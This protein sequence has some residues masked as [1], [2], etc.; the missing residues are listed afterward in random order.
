[1][2]KL[3]SVVRRNG[4]AEIVDA[5]MTQHID[6]NNENFSA[7]LL[8]LW[9]PFMYYIETMITDELSSYFSQ[10]EIQQIGMFAQEHNTTGKPKNKPPARHLECDFS[11]PKLLGRAKSILM[12]CISEYRCDVTI[13]SGE[14]HY[15]IYDNNVYDAIIS[16]SSDAQKPKF[17]CGPVL[18][19]DNT[20][21]G[22]RAEG[23][24]VS[25]LW[26]AGKLDLWCSDVRQDVH[27]RLG[28]TESLY[29]EEPH[30]S[31]ARVR[32]GWLFQNNNEVGLRFKKIAEYMINSQSV[33]KAKNLDNDF[34][35]LTSN[36][37]R[38]LKRICEEELSSGRR[39]TY[40]EYTKQDLGQL[41]KQYQ[42][43]EEEYHI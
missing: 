11:N 5:L 6:E 42:I 41:I 17:I 40:N 18:L 37:L 39:K 9:P 32:F 36:E 12:R 27:F 16:H 34:W 33:R 3:V 21:H 22:N 7:R 26:K 19:I 20:H 13:V 25:R 23:S 28:G 29:V 8:E 2:S 4:T 38:K 14:A 31:G 1:M 15:T 30:V 10:D 35:L 24:I 43:L